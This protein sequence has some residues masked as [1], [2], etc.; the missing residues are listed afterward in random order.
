MKRYLLFTYNGYYPIGGYGDFVASYD[1]FEDALKTGKE[2]ENQYFD[3]LDTEK[4]DNE[5]YTGCTKKE[6]KK[7][8]KEK[9]QIS[10]EGWNK[11]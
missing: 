10:S 7:R 4:E 11:Y 3:I 1:K 6:I 8:L 9:E 5:C 2:S